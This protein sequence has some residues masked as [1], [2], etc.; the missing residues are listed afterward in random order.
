VTAIAAPALALPTAGDWIDPQCALCGG[1]ER[2]ERFRAGAQAVVTCTTCDLTYVTPRLSPRALLEQVYDAS[3]W[4]SPVPRERGYGDYLGDAELY[5]ATFARRLRALQRW[6]PS[7]GRALDVGSGPGVF[8]DVLREAGWEI[9]GLEPSAHARKAAD[10]RLGRRVVRTGTLAEARFARGSFDLVT[11]WDV[12]EHVPDPLDALRSARALLA[13]GGRLVVETQDV[14]SLVARVLGSRWHHYKHGE[15]LHHFHRGTLRR[16][17][18]ASGFEPL[19]M[20]AGPGG[21]FVRREF[22][23][24]RSARLSPAL[25]GLLTRLARLLPEVLWIDLSDEIVCVARPNVA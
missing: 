17:L 15:H 10:S 20:R 4:S 13:P 19:S 23:L 18:R 11:F 24:E 14:G 7:T 16:A 6:L 2:R 21:K 22:L 25:P 12:L 8:L 9:A 3:Y 1:R 5:R